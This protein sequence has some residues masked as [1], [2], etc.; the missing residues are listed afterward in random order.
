MQ[1]TVTVNGSAYTREVEPRLLLIHFLRDELEL[2]V[3]ALRSAVR[4]A[5]RGDA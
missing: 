4:R 3:R 2:T 5:R 1:I